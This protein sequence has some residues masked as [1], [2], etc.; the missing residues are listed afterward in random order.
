MKFVS[1]CLCSCVCV[2]QKVVGHLWTQAIQAIRDQQQVCRQPA[3][4]SLSAQQQPASQSVAA[5]QQLS[6]CQSEASD[7]PYFS[8]GARYTSRKL[9]D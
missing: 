1:V 7:E 3:S 5:Q 8:A 6:C 2:L 4:Q 9:I